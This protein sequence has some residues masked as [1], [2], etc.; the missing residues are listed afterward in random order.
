MTKNILD[1][2]NSVQLMIDG[3]QKRR[4]R[5][6]KF[7]EKL[8]EILETVARDIWGNG[9]NDMT[10]GIVYITRIKNDK[11]EKTEIYFRYLNH[12]FDNRTEYHGFY[13]DQYSGYP[14]N[15][16]EIE[17]LRGKDFWY[18]I[19]IIIDWIPIVNNMIDKRNQSREELLQKINF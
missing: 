18:A 11:K 4:D 6:L 17:K 5:A 3:E 14:F 2:Q 10:D 19:Q 16:K 12:N 15:G 1:L 7:I 8:Q 13:D 9:E